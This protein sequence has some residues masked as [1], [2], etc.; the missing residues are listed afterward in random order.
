M[1]SN[2]MIQIRSIVQIVTLLGHFQPYWA[3]SDP[4]D[5]I[6]E[7]SH[8]CEWWLMLLHHDMQRFQSFPAKSNN[9]NVDFPK[10]SNLTPFFNPKFSV[11][12]F[13]Q[14]MRPLVTPYNT[15]TYAKN[16]KKVMNQFWE[17][18]QRP[19]FTLFLAIFPKKS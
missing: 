18:S 8:M 3:P 9:S 13:F 4:L 16:Q 7:F 12:P 10:Y 17:K 11:L 15:I 1:Q 5:P 2:Q 6:S 14:K 19:F